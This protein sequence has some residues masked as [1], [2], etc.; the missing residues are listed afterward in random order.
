MAHSDDLIH[1]DCCTLDLA[2]RML[3]RGEERQRLTSREVDLLRYLHR[4]PGRVVSKEELEREVWEFRPGVRSSAV[5]VAIRRLRNKI[6]ADPGVPQHLHTVRSL[7]WCLTLAEPPVPPPGPRHNLACPTDPFIGRQRA[8]TT[9]QEALDSPNRVCTLVGP[10]GVGKTRLAQETLTHWLEQ[11]AT[12]ELWWLALANEATASDL[13][14]ALRGAMGLQKGTLAAAFAARGP[15]LLVVDDAELSTPAHQALL[16]QWLVHPTVRLLQLARSRPGG[17]Q[18][19]LLQLGGLPLSEGT[20]LLLARTRA[21]RPAFSPPMDQ[22]HALVEAMDGLP[23]A[24]EGAATRLRVQDLP[25]LMADDTTPELLATGLTWSWERL[26]APHQQ[27]LQDLRAFAGAF[28]LNDAAAVLDTSRARSTDT[29]AALLDRGLLRAEE[30]RER[31]FRLPSTLGRYLAERH[32]IPVAAQARHRSHMLDL[33]EGW[34]AGLYQKGGLAC[35][36]ALRAA[37]PELQR[38]CAGAPPQQAARLTL[39]RAL[40]ARELGHRLALLESITPD[41]LEPTLAR[42]VWRNLADAWISRG[43]LGEAQ[44]AL[45]QVAADPGREGQF[46]LRSAVR[47]SLARGQAEGAIA[48]AEA[49]LAKDLPSPLPSRLHNDLSIAH[50]MKGSPEGA[51]QQGLAAVAEAELAQDSFS[52][53]VALLATADR[54]N[55]SGRYVQAKSAL[56]RAQALAERTGNTV[57]QGI[58]LTILGRIEERLGAMDR[59]EESLNAAGRLLMGLGCP[60]NAAIALDNLAEL[61][62]AR[63]R[64]EAADASAM[65]AMRLLVRAKD[66]RVQALAEGNAGIRTWARGERPMAKARL[67]Y[68]ISE[69]Q[70]HGLAFPAAVFSCSLAALCAEMGLAEPARAALEAGTPQGQD[71]T[72]RAAYHVSKA[73]V[74]WALDGDPAP[75]RALLTSSAEGGPWHRMDLRILLQ[76]LERSLTGQAP[77]STEGRG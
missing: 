24:L 20:T 70:R 2:Q 68:A 58:A 59:A 36:A 42:R 26:S 75:A 27:A 39:L 21:H 45:E 40:A 37:D 17:P 76:L 25:H 56:L 47:L 31:R 5:N 28:T 9:L 55:A 64:Y 4:S 10:P 38:A 72:G 29:V 8:Q 22:V 14:L 32:P 23:L 53:A 16:A 51:R 66:H 33:G 65:R 34:E 43:R 74:D 46:A 71:T 13:R 44:E 3:T 63:G 62:T 57:H 69:C 49:A 61:Q 60:V 77:P 30:S 48:L 35:M 50:S 11:D 19:A 52:L 12:R 6:E 15:V 73:H 1:L 54:L 67:E 18:G 7:G 41:E